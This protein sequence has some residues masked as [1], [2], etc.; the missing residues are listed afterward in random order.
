[1]HLLSCDF[2][3]ASG[4]CTSLPNT[5]SYSGT[6]F[7]ALDNTSPSSTGLGCQSATL[8]VPAGWVLASNNAASQGVIS[9]NPWGTYFMV[10]SGGIS[11][12]TS[13]LGGGV[14]GLS[15]SELVSSGSGYYINGCSFGV[16]GRILI[17]QACSSSG[18]SSSTSCVSCPAGTYSTASGLKMRKSFI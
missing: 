15:T 3:E 14:A 13:E 18:S 6:T 4:S 9:S 12:W 1:M 2:S 7:A 8:S 16:D 17:Q 11:Y 5:I 10:V